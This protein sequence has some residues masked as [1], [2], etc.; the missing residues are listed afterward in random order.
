MT[1]TPKQTKFSIHALHWFVVAASLSITLIAWYITKT[2][3]EEKVN[4]QFERESDQAIELIQERLSRYEDALWAGVG[5]Y[6]GSDD[7][8]SS[9]WR[10][11]TSSIN[12]ESKYKGI[13]GLGVIYKVE[14][15]ELG[16]FLSD[17]LKDQ[18]HLKIYPEHDN[19]FLLPITYI[20]PYISN[21]RAHGLDVAHE[22]NRLQAAINSFESG[23]ARITGPIVLVQD[24]E[25]TPG[26]LFY[27]PVYK[28]GR[29]YA[30][31]YAPFI[32]KKLMAGVLER[33][34]RQVSIQIKDENE[35][36][37]S[38]EVYE[39]SRH[40]AKRTVSVYGRDWDF[41]IN[42]DKTFLERNYS[43]KPLIILI[44]GLIIDILLV[45]L[46]LL[47][48][49]SKEKLKAQAEKIHND[50]EE[51]LASRIKAEKKAAES[52]KAK[53]RF[54]A[55]MS[56]EIRT[57]MN[58]VIG[59]SDL[60]LDDPSLG[61]KTK[62]IVEMI[63]EAG[64]SLLGIINDILDFSK[65]EAGKLELKPSKF[66]L[67]SSIENCNYILSAKASINNVQIIYEYNL[68]SQS[69]IADPIRVKQVIINLL[70]NAVK[71][72]KNGIVTIQVNRIN[73]D[74][75]VDIIDTGIG[76]KQESLEELF[77]PFMQASESS[78]D[79]GGTGLGLSIS[80]SLAEM[81]GGD[82]E[83]TSRLGKGSHFKFSFK[84]EV[85]DPAIESE[86]DEST[87]STDT[88]T[89]LNIAVAEDNL[90]NQKMIGI[91]LSKLQCKFEIF[92]NGKELVDSINASNSSYDLILMDMRM[93]VMD[94][95]EAT[96]KILVRYPEQ[97]I[98]ALTANASSDDRDRCLRAGMTDFLSKPIKIRDI[99]RVILDNIKVKS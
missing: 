62:Q 68:E 38:E 7:L 80:K 40:Q 33:S 66:N 22:K 47:N 55:N 79:Y 57:P 3:I 30:L 8:T 48:S 24:E 2:S 59:L 78:T 63:N 58:G 96:K 85:C 4:R 74:I 6:N 99:E 72:T 64:E 20:E 17:H 51:E 31:V 87:S 89:N 1:Q 81:M 56:H 93:P 91:I 25:Q 92:N 90:I 44:A 53:S 18:P 37:Y 9:D 41:Q 43:A 46:F 49:H 35:D 88:Y 10:G 50:Y 28:Q 70:S 42:S 26:F 86:V 21:K 77:T 45:T 34:K 65:I 60:L 76:M 27:A 19:E 39:N 12:I 95:L 94:G 61:P 71:F 54:L 69:I 23:K 14:R 83:V 97:Q 13:N 16:S 36:L 29:A 32:F 11:F 73:D 67:K 84:G 15:K 98:I 82:I 52:A 5:F 75:F